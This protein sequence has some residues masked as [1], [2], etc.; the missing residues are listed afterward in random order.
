MPTFKGTKIHF[1][2]FKRKSVSDIAATIS[3]KLPI[4]SRNLYNTFRTYVVSN[5]IVASFATATIFE[6]TYTTREKLLARRAGAREKERKNEKR[7]KS[8]NL[9]HST[10]LI[11]ATSS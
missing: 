10:L 8:A 4:I 7:E 2:S 1:A 9:V 6:Y 3:I 11:E 5:K